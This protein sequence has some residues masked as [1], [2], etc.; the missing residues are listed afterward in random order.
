MGHGYQSNEQESGLL[1]PSLPTLTTP[2]NVR[3][4]G[5]NAI[6]V[7]HTPELTMQDNSLLANQGIQE[8]DKA[9]EYLEGGENQLLRTPPSVPNEARKEPSFGPN[10]NNRMITV[11]SS[12]KEGENVQNRAHTMRIL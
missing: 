12:N 3:G 5:S 1:G 10:V 4:R 2:R 11:E 8:D 9:K 7:T 6:E